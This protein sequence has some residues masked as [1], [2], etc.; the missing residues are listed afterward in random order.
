MRGNVT[1]LVLADSH[2]TQKDG[3]GTP[4]LIYCTREH[5]L[6]LANL[7]DQ[8]KWGFSTILKNKHREEDGSLTDDD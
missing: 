6:E 7:G 5:H 1:H 8:L 2:S 3:P 4:F